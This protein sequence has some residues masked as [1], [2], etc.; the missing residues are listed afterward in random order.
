M[1]ETMI[2]R[3]AV[4]ACV[5]L[6]ALTLWGWVTEP[7]SRPRGAVATPTAVVPRSADA[8]W[9]VCRL[10]ENG[11]EPAEVARLGRDPRVRHAIAVGAATLGEQGEPYRREL[12]LTC[13]RAGVLS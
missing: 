4:L 9:A 1:A 6:I 2:K 10:A 13:R 7:P 11:G 12:L 3:A 5:G 8:E